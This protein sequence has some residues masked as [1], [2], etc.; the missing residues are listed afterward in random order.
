MSPI[1]TKKRYKLSMPEIASLVRITRPDRKVVQGSC[2]VMVM[3][4]ELCGHTKCGKDCTC[5]CKDKPS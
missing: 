2:Y 5:E 3:P 1:Q 4:C